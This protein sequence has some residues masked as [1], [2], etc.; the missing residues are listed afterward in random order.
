MA[1]ATAVQD[2]GR[3]EIE[4]MD[5]VAR[6]RVWAP[7]DLA[8]LWG[9]S[10][11]TLR[12]KARELGACHVLGKTMWLTDEDVEAIQEATRLR[13][14]PPIGVK[15]IG[16]TGGQLPGASYEEV[17]ARLRNEQRNGSRRNK[18]RNTGKVISMALHRS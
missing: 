9:C 12:A 13:P 15:E 18:K 7:S 2:R 10:E 1:I 6:H 5:D 4:M 3:G 11:R 17:R 14:M 8:K 16:I